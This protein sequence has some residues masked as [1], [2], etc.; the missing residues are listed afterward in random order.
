MLS[1]CAVG[2]IKTLFKT[3]AAVTFYTSSTSGAS[4]TSIAHLGNLHMLTL[5]GTTL[6]RFP[7]SNVQWDMRYNVRWI[8]VLLQSQGGNV[9]LDMTAIKH[10]YKGFRVYLCPS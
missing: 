1:A 7:N 8:I 3:I 2:S 6:T 4:V 5:E 10:L 9:P